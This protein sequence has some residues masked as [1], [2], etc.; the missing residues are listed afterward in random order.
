MSLFLIDLGLIAIRRDISADQKCPI[1]RGDF[2]DSDNL[3]LRT[4]RPLF[5]IW[6]AKAGEK[7]FF[8]GDNSSHRLTWCII[9]L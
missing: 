3:I 6:W 7:R 5:S 9:G 1:F 4:P 8:S 2:I